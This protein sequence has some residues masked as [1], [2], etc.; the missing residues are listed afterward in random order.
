MLTNN[1]GSRDLYEEL[2]REIFAELAGV[3]MPRPLAPPEPPLAD[4]A[5]AIAPYVGRYERAGVNMDVLV[6]E[7]GPMLRTEVVGP[8]AEM[9]PDPVDEYPLVPYG[10][11]LFLTK[12]PE[13]ETWFPVTFYELPTGERYLH[14]GAR[15]TPKVSS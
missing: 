11:A 13:A 9:V 8:L 7:D 12:P 10:P 3:E 2:Y 1:D 15:A 5:G 14:F 6:G 4:P